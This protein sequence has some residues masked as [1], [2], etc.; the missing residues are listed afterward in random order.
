LCATGPT[1]NTL[2]SGRTKRPGRAP[3]DSPSSGQVGRAVAKLEISAPGAVMAIVDRDLAIPAVL[4]VAYSEWS[5]LELVKSFSDRDEGAYAELVRRHTPSVSWVARTTL[6]RHHGCDDVV[7]EVFES[8]WLAPEKFDPSRGTVL[9]LLRMR[10]KGLSIDTVRSEVR[11]QSREESAE[12]EKSRA[13]QAD[14]DRG[15][16]VADSV[17][18]THEALTSLPRSESDPIYLAYFKGMTYRAVAAQLGV[19]EGTVKSRIR[20]GL[21]RLRSSV[22]LRSYFDGSDAVQVDPRIEGTS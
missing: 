20:S 1:L 14:I 15:L 19:P 21:I 8:L 13:E 18:E 4:V 7:A 3:P 2:R 11:R 12:K 10:A 17:R 6:G 16:V 9:R 5:D 22:I